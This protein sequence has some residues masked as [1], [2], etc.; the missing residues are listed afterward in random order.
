[1]NLWT[2]INFVSM[3][4]GAFIITY[5]DSIAVRALGMITVVSGAVYLASVGG[6]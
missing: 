2:V 3:V 1:M 5:S 4:A 6:V